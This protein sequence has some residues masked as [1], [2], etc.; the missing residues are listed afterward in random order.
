MAKTQKQQQVVTRKC[1]NCGEQLPNDE[2]GMP[3]SS[4]YYNWH[5]L[6]PKCRFDK[7][8]REKFR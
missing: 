6:C 5:W 7:T 3:V 8:A 2:R 1:A 4:I